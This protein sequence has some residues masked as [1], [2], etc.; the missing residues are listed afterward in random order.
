MSIL[1]KQE[2]IGIIESRLKG[3][4]YSKYSL[5]VD[6]L[7]ENAKDTP[8]PEVLTKISESLEEIANQLSVLNAEMA[9]IDSLTE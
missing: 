4:E 1:T 6:Q 2:M 5:E 8:G 7:V 3:L 9:R